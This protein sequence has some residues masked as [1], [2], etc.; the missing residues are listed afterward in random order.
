MTVRRLVPALLA[1][2]LVLLTACTSDHTPEK[3]NTS[4]I[5]SLLQASDVPGAQD[6]HLVDTL[7]RTPFCGPVDDA[8]AFTETFAEDRHAISQLTVGPA[9]VE[10][11]VYDVKFTSYRGQ[12]F[13]RGYIRGIAFCSTNTLSLTDVDGTGSFGKM[14]PLTDLPPGAVGYSLAVTGKGGD[15]VQLR[16]YAMVD[17]K[18]IVV[19]ATRP[20]TQAPD[21]A[22]GSLMAKAIAKV[23]TQT[24]TQQAQPA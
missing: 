24:S 8:E 11:A 13:D 15:S 19:A 17:T 5:E 3:P 22:L 23:T 21:I 12:L 10:S 9:T 2:A 4:G 16:A 1:T 7:G 18:V 20:G 14:T 6:V